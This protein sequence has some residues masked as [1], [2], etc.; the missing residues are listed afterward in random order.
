M[1]ATSVVTPRVTAARLL[2]TASALRPRPGSNAMRTPTPTGNGA[3][4]SA[5]ARPQNERRSGTA[6][7]STAVPAARHA[8]HAASTTTSAATPTAPTTRTNR[9]R[10]NP[11]SGSAV[12]A[13]PVG[14]NVDAAAAVTTA[15]I[16]PPTPITAARPRPSANRPRRRMPNAAST[17]ASLC[18]VNITP[19]QELAE[20]QRA[21]D[22]REQ[23]KDPERDRLRVHRP[24]HARGQVALHDEAVG[25][26]EPVERPEEAVEVA[27]AVLEAHHQLVGALREEREVVLHRV[28]RRRT[29]GSGTG[30]CPRSAAGTRRAMLRCRRSSTGCPGRARAPVCGRPTP[31]PPRRGSD[32]EVARPARSD[33]ALGG[34][35]RRAGGIGRR[36]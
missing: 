28:Q 32:R 18:S 23:G 21:G 30:R 7:D 24:V 16:P 31:S 14:K 33:R 29:R 10:W 26:A 20:N 22:G 13:T 6:S 35:P 15:T 4:A 5:L 1:A 8:G 17:R 2:R 9:S 27:T 25:C 19:R 34:G 11:G 3:L 36:G 12:R